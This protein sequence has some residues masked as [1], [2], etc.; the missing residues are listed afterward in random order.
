LA[1]AVR[2]ASDTYV[3]LIDG[4]HGELTVSVDGNV[5]ARKTDALPTVSEV[6]KRVEE[7]GSAAPTH[8]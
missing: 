1:A 2:K 3:Q 4:D 6:L 5:V 7:A 8:A